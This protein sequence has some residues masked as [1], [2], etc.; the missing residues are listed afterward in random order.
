MEPAEQAPLLL[1]GATLIPGRHQTTH[2]Q[3]TCSVYL[4]IPKSSSAVVP[5]PDQCIALQNCK[6][7]VLTLCFSL[8]APAGWESVAEIRHTPLGSA[9]DSSAPQCQEARN[10]FYTK[11]CLARLWMH[12]GY[13]GDVKE[14]ERSSSP[15]SLLTFSKR[16]R[17]S[18]YLLL[19]LL[20]ST[21]S[22]PFDPGFVP[23]QQNAHLPSLAPLVGR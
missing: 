12:R 5:L 7:P 16:A 1:K 13:G 2:M 11:H 19:L 3:Q 21:K 18:P 22:I 23:S 4:P 15:V 6:Q 10:M 17:T 9:P 14:K 8:S 20:P